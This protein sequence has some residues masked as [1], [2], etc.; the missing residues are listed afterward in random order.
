MLNPNF[1]RCRN[2]DAVH[3]VTAFD[4]APH[5]S[6]SAGGANETVA[7]DWHDFMSSHAGHRLEP[8]EATGQSY[9]SDGRSS[10]PMASGF[11]EAIDGKETVLLRRVRSTIQEP[12]RF[13]WVPGRLVPGEST[14]D[15]QENALRKEMKL[16]FPWAPAEPLSDQKIDL[17]VQLYRQVVS[18]LDVRAVYDREFTLVD[19]NIVYGHLDAA[20]WSTLLDN[21]RSCFTTDE[22]AALHRFIDCHRDADDVLAVVIRRGMAVEQ[23]L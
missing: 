19:D 23:R 9:F 15:V 21:C 8:L 4:K 16:H 20:A 7:N 2:C 11:I 14:L 5:Y 22:V 13:E 1:I 3:H 10:D 18:G 17:F 12:L 6:V